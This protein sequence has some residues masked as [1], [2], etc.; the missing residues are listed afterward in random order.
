VPRTLEKFFALVDQ[1]FGSPRIDRLFAECGGIE[2]G[3]HLRGKHIALVREVL[4]PALDA[5]VSAVVR[6]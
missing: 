1:P 5:C 6:T 3:L 2:Y 4:N